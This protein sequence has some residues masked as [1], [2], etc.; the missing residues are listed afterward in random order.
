M[1]RPL[2]ITCIRRCFPCD[3]CR[4]WRYLPRSK[5]RPRTG[6]ADAARMVLRCKILVY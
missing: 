6:R 2:R 4:A 3:R 5:P 1:A